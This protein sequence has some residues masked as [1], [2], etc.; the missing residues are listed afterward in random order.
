MESGLNKVIH[1]ASRC[2]LSLFQLGLRLLDHSLNEGLFIP[3][4]FTPARAG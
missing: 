3:V 2:D 4:A 1:T